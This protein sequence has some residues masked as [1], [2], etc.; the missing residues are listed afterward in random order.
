VFGQAFDRT[1]SYAQPLILSAG[2]LLAGAALL[3][4]LGRYRRFDGVA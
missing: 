1:G 3:L 2:L 4:T